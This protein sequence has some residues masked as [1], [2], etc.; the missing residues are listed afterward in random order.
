MHDGDVGDRINSVIVDRNNCTQDELA[1]FIEDSLEELYIF[2]EE[3]FAP[4]TGEEVY[5]VDINKHRF[6][7]KDKHKKIKVT[8]SYSDY[9]F[10]SDGL[11]LGG[12]GLNLI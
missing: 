1:S 4:I 7:V 5:N 8:S 9:D 11:G 10:S 3:S 2:R 12:Y 6:K